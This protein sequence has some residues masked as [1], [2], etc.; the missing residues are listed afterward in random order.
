MKRN[1]CIAELLG[2]D[3]SFEVKRR[4][5]RKEFI[6]EDQ[7]QVDNKSGCLSNEE[8]KITIFYVAVDSVGN[9]SWQGFQQDLRQEN[10]HQPLA[11]HGYM[12]KN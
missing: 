5:K 2:I 3:P 6:D 11:F 4:R 12:W 9:L 1:R 7:E 10:L 8:F